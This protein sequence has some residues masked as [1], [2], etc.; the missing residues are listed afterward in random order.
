MAGGEPFDS[1]GPT[2]AWPA[3]SEEVTGPASATGTRSARVRE[4]PAF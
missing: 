4:Y 2:G 3:G 1:S